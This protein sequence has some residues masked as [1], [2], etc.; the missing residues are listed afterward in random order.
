MERGHFYTPSRFIASH[1][2]LLDKRTI[3][4][5]WSAVLLPPGTGA[6]LFHVTLSVLLD[7]SERGEI[8]R[9]DAA[10]LAQLAAALR[11]HLTALSLGMVISGVEIYTAGGA[12]LTVMGHL[13][14][15]LRIT[16]RAERP[17]E[18]VRMLQLDA[19]GIGH[20]I[21]CTSRIAAAFSF[22]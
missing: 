18:P 15:A 10:E 8:I 1:P 5:E 2:A 22:G 20:A 13:S 4:L 9:L 6:A 7:E 14:P 3:D 21:G 16:L 19:D 12:K 17:G 11:E